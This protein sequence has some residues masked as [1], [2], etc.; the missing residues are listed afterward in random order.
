MSWVEREGVVNSMNKEN[1]NKLCELQC[2]HTRS[3]IRVLI[4]LLDSNR[5]MES[6]RVI[7]SA[8]RLNSSI[9][10][11]LV[12]LLSNTYLIFIYLFICQIVV[13]NHYYDLLISKR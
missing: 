5:S 9:C 6:A 1:E 2:S 11:Q 10:I 8:K 13:Y 7:R 4:R 3:V 12:T